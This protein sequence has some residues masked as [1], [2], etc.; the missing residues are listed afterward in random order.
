MPKIFNATCDKV[1]YFLCCHAVDIVFRVQNLCCYFI[2]PDNAR[3]NRMLVFTRG[4]GDVVF[5]D[6][7]YLKLET[8]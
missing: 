5:G 2:V 6:F 8:F 3:C 7:F 1:V 4:L